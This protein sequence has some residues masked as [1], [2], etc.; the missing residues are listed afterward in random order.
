MARVVYWAI[1]LA[2]LAELAA[3]I[4]Y[5]GTSTAAMLRGDIGIGFDG[6]VAALV[7]TF[8]AVIANRVIARFFPAWRLH[9]SRWGRQP[10]PTQPQPQWQQPRGPYSGGG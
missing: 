3:V 10:M 8:V 7:L 2:I 1:L 5:G 4:Y 9:P 6:A